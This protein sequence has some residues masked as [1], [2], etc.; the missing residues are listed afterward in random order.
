LCSVARAF[1]LMPQTFWTGVGRMA[2]QGLKQI[3]VDLFHSRSIL[4]LR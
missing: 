4:V 2:T 1:G 3:P